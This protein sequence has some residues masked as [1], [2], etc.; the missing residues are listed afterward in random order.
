[1]RRP[2]RGRSPDIRAPSA[3]ARSRSRTAWRAD[4]SGDALRRPADH[5]IGRDPHLRAGVAVA[6]RDRLVGERLPVDG[7]A[8]RRAG[9]VHAR[10][11]L[12][13]ALLGVVL[14]RPDAA[15][16]VVVDALGD[17]GH[18]FLV[19]EREDAGLHRRQAGMEAHQLG[20]RTAL[21]DAVRLAQHGEQ[22][23]RQAG[24]RLDDMR[25]VALVA[26][27]VEVLELDAAHALVLAQIVVAAVGDALE[28]A[29]A[30]LAR[31]RKGI[32]DI[33]APAGLLCVVRQLVLLVVAEPQLLA[34]EPHPSP[35]G[36]GGL[37]RVAVPEIGLARMDEELELHLLELARAEDVVARRQLVA[38]AAPD[39]A[40][41]ERHLDAR[42]VEDVLEVVEHPLRRLRTEIRLR[43]VVAHGADP[44]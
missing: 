20:R 10:V 38:E 24:R 4:A 17:L 25:Q 13:D 37:A 34:R 35:P 7:D 15:P 8:E 30:L 36:E 16:Q 28:L 26:L 23:A 19:H 41:A 1:M 21:V 6:Y 43:L 5:L 31:E 39:L 32:L 42:R 9:L 11:A 44:G 2:P 14:A 22:A 18:A 12:P 33:A 40:D 27:G 3:T 29:E